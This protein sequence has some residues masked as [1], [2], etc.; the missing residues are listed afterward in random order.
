MEQSTTEVVQTPE[1]GAVSEEPGM[2]YPTIVTS[3]NLQFED[4][5]YKEDKLK[6]K[7]SIL[8]KVPG[9][10]TCAECGDA[11]PQWAA[12][13]LGIFVC[14]TCSGAHRNL[15]VH[16]S[17]VKSLFLDNWKRDELEIMRDTGNTKSLA[18]WEANKPKCFVKPCLA[19]SSI[20]KE[21]F[22]RAKYERKEYCADTKRESKDGLPQKEGYLTKRGIVVKNWKRRWFVQQGSLLLYYKKQSDPFPAGEILLN[23]ATQID[24]LAESVDNKAFCFVIKTPG[25]EFF[26]SADN[27]KE[28]YDWIQSMR[29]A[30]SC[31]NTTK[32]E[33]HS[34]ADINVKDIIAKISAGVPVGKR[35]LNKKTFLNAFF[36][37]S[38]VDWLITYM[39]AKSRAEAVIVGQKLMD[40]GFVQSCTNEKFSDGYSLYQFLKTQ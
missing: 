40:E 37:V 13:S 10:G 32:P 34:A 3:E 4:D 30:K 2:L 18:I 5:L 6:E 21:N 27:G 22:I 8:L 17:R 31:L 14:I 12:A 16:I 19:D 24:C 20:L 11:D 28:M 15:G 23:E 35:K 36:G 38:L 7:M 1:E 33:G 25:R 26:I 29:A 9:N 39:E